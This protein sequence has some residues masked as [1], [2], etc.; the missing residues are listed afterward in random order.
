MTVI[1]TNYTCYRWAISIHLVKDK[2]GRD[3]YQIVRVTPENTFCVIASERTERAARATANAEWDADRRNCTHPHH[4]R[5][6]VVDGVIRKG[7]P[8]L[9]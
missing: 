4:A 3:L 9:Y 7:E 5:G 8:V 1:A 2:T 6:K